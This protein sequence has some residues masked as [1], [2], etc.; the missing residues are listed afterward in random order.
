MIQALP[1][2]SLYIHIP[3]CVRKCPYCDFNSHNQPDALPVDE[4]ITALMHDLAVD[5]P[6]V[7]GRSLQSIFFGGGTP[8]L[9]SAEAMKRIIN[10][11]RSMVPLSPSCEVT[12]ECNPGT[13]EHDRFAG[14]LAAGI[15]RISFGVQSFDDAQLAALGRIHDSRQA[16]R[17]IETAKVEGFERIN[18][19]LMYALPNQNTEQALADLRQAIALAPEHISHYHLTIEPNTLF[20]AKPPKHLPDLD[21]A[22][23]MQDACQD[24]LAKHG[25]AAYE[26]SAYAQDGR[27]CQHNLN[28]WRFG[29][30]LG[31]GAGAHGKVTDATSGT[32][33]RLSKQRH[34]RT[35]IEHC[36]AP[37]DSSDT[38]H[39]QTINVLGVR[40]LPYEFMMN[41]LRL[42]EPFPIH[43]FTKRTGLPASVLNAPKQRAI[44]MGLLETQGDQ[45]HV[46]KHGRNFLND[47]VVLFMGDDS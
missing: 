20:A 3:W 39:Q 11:V 12:M 18:I 19:D 47:L 7:Q 25:Y 8:S 5:L 44:D 14:Y 17:A 31:I 45:W 30:Y 4:Y 24:L 16:I 6:W 22:F 21:D 43:E 33:T 29:D 37:N 28:Y 35:Y 23:A 42:H 27:Q 40:E 2:L 32:I 15:N 13:M 34:P 9:F 10:G 26:V 46:T 1:P 36:L 38:S 41:R